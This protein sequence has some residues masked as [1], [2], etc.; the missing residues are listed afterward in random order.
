MNI[1][2]KLKKSAVV[3]LAAA[4]TACYPIDAL[5]APT[6]TDI[7][8]FK[9]ETPADSSSP[10]I[11]TESETEITAPSATEPETEITE[12]PAPEPNTVSFCA[13]GDNLIHE[14]IYMQA[15]TENGY[16]FS[17]AYKGI[18]DIIERADLAVINQE[19]LI[20]N[21]MYEPSTYPY[22]NSPKALGDY[23]IEMGFDVFTLA[24][25]HC[26]D[27][28][29]KGLSHTLDYWEGKKEVTAG[30]YRNTEDKNKIRTSEFGGITFSFLSYTQFLNGLSLPEGSEM[31]IGDVNDLKGMI[32][33]I[34]AAKQISDVCVVALHWGV[35]DYHTIE[36]W[37]RNYAQALADAG[38]DIIIGNHP[39]VLRDI[40][41]IKRQDGG[42]TLCAYSLGN[43]ISAQSKAANL[44]S[45]I[46]Q[47]NVTMTDE[48]EYAVFSD[49]KLIPIVTHYDSDKTNVRLYKLSDYSPELASAHGVRE[50]DEFGYDFILEVLQANIDEKYLV[51]P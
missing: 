17:P 44:I 22:F 50:Y 21:D 18:R 28:G 16:D 12:P 36:D 39:H 30:T 24:N 6:N 15:K 25:N 35:E 27:Y 4:L 20:C 48:S 5:P 31:V 51:L 13:V 29:E 42:E 46:L 26:L 33:D 2:N 32:A 14:P 19:T 47:F 11:T 34:K 43:F 37:Q 9:T 45:G 49:I 1:I 23:M 10:T 7:S 40:E 8:A 41:T 38:A 3:L